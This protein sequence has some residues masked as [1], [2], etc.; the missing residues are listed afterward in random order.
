MKRIDTPTATED[1]KFRDGNKSTGVQATQFNA[2][3]CNDI[4][5]EIC[6][7]IKL[8]TGND[9][10]GG[11]QSE[12]ASALLRSSLVFLEKNTANYLSL[13][14][15]VSKG[16]TPV[17]VDAGTSATTTSRSYYLPDANVIDKRDPTQNAGAFRFFN[18]DTVN[19]KIKILVY[20]EN[21]EN[22][23]EMELSLNFAT[24]LITQKVGTAGSS[25]DI[26][27]GFFLSAVDLLLSNQFNEGGSA[28]V[29]KVQIKWDDAS[30][31]YDVVIDAGNIILGTG[32]PKIL[33]NKWMNGYADRVGTLQNE[34][35]C[36]AI[37]MEINNLSDFYAEEIVLRPG[38]IEFWSSKDGTFKK[39]NEI[40]M[41]NESLDDML[42]VDGTSAGKV[43][44]MKAKY[45]NLGQTRKVKNTSGSNVTVD[46]VLYASGQGQ[47]ITFRN[48]RYREFVCVGFAS[49]PPGPDTATYLLP[50]DNY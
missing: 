32:F 47:S 3:W 19:K 6:N 22:P 10:I 45:W 35:G 36:I 24:G 13:K 30:H 26:Q 17:I 31:D 46:S 4:Q 5:E 34:A 27:T 25:T 23:T 14:A 38:S 42:A 1:H 40:L 48:G 44:W 33:I 15:A 12:M 16:S 37:A 20:T 29:R 50:G 49:N 2:R 18:V 28:Q 41:Q 39:V 11:T 21:A 8:F 7:V 43:E 9:P